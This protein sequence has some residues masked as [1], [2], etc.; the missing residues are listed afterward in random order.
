MRANDNTARPDPAIL[1]EAADWIDRLDELT[2]VERRELD[3]WLQASPDHTAAYASLRHTLL[4]PALLDAVDHVRGGVHRMQGWSVPPRSRRA[5]PTRRWAGLGLVAASLAVV[6]A[7][8]TIGLS[9][10]D[11]GDEAPVEFATAIGARAEHHLSDAS[12]VHLNA[13]SRLR[14]VFNKASRDVHLQKGDALFDVAKNP[15]RPFSVQAGDATVTAVGTSFEVELV[16]DAVEVR[17]YEGAVQVSRGDAPLR[18]VRRG[19]WLLLTANHEADAGRFEPEAYPDW[20][21]DWLAAE[22]MPL[23]YVVARLNR[24]SRDQV[25]LRQDAIGD[26]KV[27]GRFK[28]SRTADALAMISALLEVDAAKDGRNIYLSP[29]RSEPPQPTRAV[30]GG[31]TAPI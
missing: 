16:S 19:E 28:L 17:V 9:I 31:R 10:L 26:L 25:V 27:T 22:N 20:R 24:Y 15:D 6:V 12:V 29:R 4:D 5:A 13:D 18:T 23:K 30:G 7:A 21:S 2:E 8:S 11:R 3:A 1:E 14:V